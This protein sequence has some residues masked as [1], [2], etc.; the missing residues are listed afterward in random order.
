[1]K[2]LINFI[3]GFFKQK[4]YFVTVFK[5]EKAIG[6]IYDFHEIALRNEK[7]TAPGVFPKLEHY[8]KNRIV[9]IEHVQAQSFPVPNLVIT[10]NYKS[11]RNPYV[12]STESIIMQ[13]KEKMRSALLESTIGCKKL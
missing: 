10:E 11:G 3:F 7:N 8:T 2:K 9:D 6:G 12:S 4:P 13:Q 1:M 5:E